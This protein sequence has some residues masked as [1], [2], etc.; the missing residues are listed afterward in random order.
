VE[1]TSVGNKEKTS[2][3]GNKEKICEVHGGHPATHWC[4]ECEQ[5][6]CKDLASLHTKISPALS[7]HHVHLLGEAVSVSHKPA[8]CNKHG[9]QL[10][11]A[12]I[13]D[14]CLVC[15]AC[16]ATTCN[17]HRCETIDEHYEKRSSVIPKLLADMVQTLGNIQRAQEVVKAE[18]Q[19]VEKNGEAVKAEVTAFFDQLIDLKKSLLMNVETEMALR[20]KTLEWQLEGLASHA[21][22]VQVALQQLEMMAR[23]GDKTKTLALLGQLEEQHF[24]LNDDYQLLAHANLNF[25]RNDSIFSSKI[26]KIGFEKPDKLV[27]KYSWSKQQLANVTIMGNKITSS[28]KR[29]WGMINEEFGLEANPLHLRID[30][31]ATNGWAEVVLYPNPAIQFNPGSRKKGD[32]IVS[33]NLRD[34]NRTSKVSLI[35][36]ERGNNGDVTFKVNGNIVSTKQAVPASF[37]YVDVY[38][39]TTEAE[40]V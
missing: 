3:A 20:N 18:K 23:I 8:L 17:G 38:H 6:M 25:V 5:A 1:A 4:H 30:H 15:I 13:Q 14:K 32:D 22:S 34:L 29:A 16:I 10:E 31:K 24:T 26:D 37:I 19:A 40:I 7:T 36:V 2:L 11:L 28:S 27:S 35:I 33:I 21:G 12:C 39:P 9:K